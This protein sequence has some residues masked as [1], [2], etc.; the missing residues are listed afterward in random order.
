AIRSN[1]RARSGSAMKPAMPHMRLPLSMPMSRASTTR[2]EPPQP[3]ASGGDRVRI[4]S[5]LHVGKN[6]A[7]DQLLDQLAWAK[8]DVGLMRYRGDDCVR[9]RQR[10]PLGQR[11]AILVL[12]LATVGERVV[13]Q[14]LAAVA[15]QLA[16][17]VDD[18]GV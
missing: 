5:A 11:N 8:I 16:Y 13:D 1:G 14:N 7:W 3:G 17:D 4:V 2:S 6:A 12:A 10:L 18:L 9:G 15:L